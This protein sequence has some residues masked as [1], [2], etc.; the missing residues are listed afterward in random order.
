[1]MLVSIMLGGM[2]FLNRADEL[3]RLER[4]HRAGEGGLAVVYGRRRVGKTRLLLEWCARHDGV[5]F[6]ADQ[7]TPVL[8]RAA[9]ASAVGR[10]LPGFGDV[11]YPSWVALLDRLA[12]DAVGRRFRGPLVVD[13]LPYLVTA[14][15]ELPSVLQSWLDHAARQARLVVA[16]AGSQQRMMQG[17]VLDGASPLYGRAVEVLPVL[18]L[19][20]RWIAQAFPG[21]GPLEQLQTWTATGGIPRYW[22]LLERERGPI[23]SRV[24]RLVL[25]PLGPLHLEPDRLLLEEDPPAVELRPLLEAIGAGAHRVSEIAARIG[26][27]A[28]ALSRPFE[29]LVGLGLVR[30]EVPFGESP[31]DT[32]RSLYRLADPLMRLWFRLVAPR[33]GLMLSSTSGARLKLLVEA[34]PHLLAEAWEELARASVPTLGSAG[35]F[36]AQRAWQPGQRWWQGSAP[37]WDVVSATDDDSVLLLGEARAWERP[38]PLGTVKAA[39]RALRE[40]PAPAVRTRATELVR[41]LF[42]PRVTRDVP[43]QVDGVCVVTAAEV[44]SAS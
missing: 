6:V 22:E 43:A 29:R 31:R 18:P 3:K 5:Y 20:P 26:R 40:R 14:S 41:V 19:A 24:E 30:R 44:L 39:A 11:A 1:M 23:L 38:A 13:E 9:L 15:P 42:V 35:R 8:Q 34:M 21:F 36:G 17:L 12:A 33:R 37:E 32:R 2:K 10:R 7:S 28:T 27:A 4:L 25:D 16:L